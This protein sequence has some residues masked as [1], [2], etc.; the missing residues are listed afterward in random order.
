MCGE[1][2]VETEEVGWSQ[3]PK[4]LVNFYKCVPYPKAWEAIPGTA[5][6]W[7]LQLETGFLTHLVHK[8]QFQ[9]DYGSKYEMQTVN[10]L[11]DIQET[12]PMT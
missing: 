3:V 11:E 2:V 12:I 5:L 4:G 8:S 1:R 7:I 10:H 6:E 9:V